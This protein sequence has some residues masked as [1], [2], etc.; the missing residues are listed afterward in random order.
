MAALWATRTV[1]QPQGQSFYR[2]LTFAGFLLLID[3]RRRPPLWHIGLAWQWAMVGLTVL[4]FCFCWWARLHIGKLWSASI[5]RKQDHRVVD[6]GPYGLV[7][8]PIYTGLI[9]SGFASAVVRG[10]LVS[11]A[12]AL[13][14]VLAWYIKARLEERF[15]RAEL[16]A[17]AYNVYAA[18]VPMLIPFLKI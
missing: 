1:R 6:S 2:L 3:P 8:H 10:T 16:G 5:T 4:G 17:E 7:R 9:L 18:R 13:L 12:G 11:V 14:L 15:L